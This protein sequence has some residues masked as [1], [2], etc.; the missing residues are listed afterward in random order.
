MGL[1]FSFTPAASDPDHPLT[2]SPFFLLKIR[3]LF[4]LK[5]VLP[6]PAGLDRAENSLLFTSRRTLSKAWTASKDLEMF[7]Q[8]YP[9]QLRIRSPYPLTAPKDRPRT[10]CFWMINARIT[11]GSAVTVAATAIWP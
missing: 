9:S 7:F 3:L 8:G 6:A 11:S 2:R 5:T 4:S 1:R 10:R